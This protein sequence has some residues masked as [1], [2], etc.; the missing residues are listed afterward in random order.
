M[1][2][3]HIV[4]DWKVTGPVENVLGLC[5][6]LKRHGTDVTIMCGEARARGNRI[7][8][9]ARALGLDIMAH[10]EIRKH[11]V[12]LQWLVDLLSGARPEMGR[13]LQ[14]LK[15][16]L[17][18]CHLRWGRALG[19]RWAEELGVP[20]VESLYDIPRERVRV[21]RSGN[22]AR[23]YVVPVERAKEV[24]QR[25]SGIPE[26][27]VVVAMP[28]VDRE[29]FD[30]DRP[31]PDKRSAFGF[32]DCEIVVGIVARVQRHRMFGLLLE[33]FRAAYGEEPRL[34]LLVVGRGT[35]REDLVV[36]P[37]RRMGLEPAVVFAGYLE[38]EDYVGALKAMDVKVFLVPGTDGTCRA[39]RQA[40]AMGKPVIVSKRGLLPHIVE[41]GTS[42]LVIEEEPAS[43]ARAI[44]T[45][46]RD[47]AL[48][49]SLGR[50]ALEAAKTR[51]SASAE[52]QAVS[53]LY[54]VLL[55]ARQS[56]SRPTP[57]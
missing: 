16:D 25:L 49:A 6:E 35:H 51:F 29:R 27:R 52:V 42:G 32:S 7:E 38:G 10:R 26:D 18:H 21:G 1:R 56:L 22:V 53:R 57:G 40:M 9:V 12:M 13:V 54:R 8:D 39:L 5:R 14:G 17:L 45:L 24:L 28:G 11:G 44:V 19:E 47:E 31:V 46:A 33:A 4:S 3:V 50:G 34:R 20:L 41:D 15:P 23:G 48:R 36:E 30:P 37:V 55:S 43:L 2:V